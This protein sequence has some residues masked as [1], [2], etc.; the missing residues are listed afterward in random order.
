MICRRPPPQWPCVAARA[1]NGAL[2]ISS[3][4]CKYRIDYLCCALNPVPGATRT[5]ALP[6]FEAGFVPNGAAGAR[7]AHSEQS[8]NDFVYPTGAQTYK[9]D[10]LINY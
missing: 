2:G 9:S 5:A 1:A 7:Y 3:V 10:S 8:F 6:L 4:W